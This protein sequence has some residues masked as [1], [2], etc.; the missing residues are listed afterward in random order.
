MAPRGIQVRPDFW[1][2]PSGMYKYAEQSI[3]MTPS[4]TTSL[5]CRCGN[6]HAY[7]CSAQTPRRPEFYPNVDIDIDDLFSVGR[8]QELEELVNSPWASAP[9]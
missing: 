2:W 3:F 4:P 8:T 5:F 7:T 6:P 9:A 1:N